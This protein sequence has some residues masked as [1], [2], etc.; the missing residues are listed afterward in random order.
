MGVVVRPPSPPKGGE[1]S[2]VTTTLEEQQT[3]LEHTD[4]HRAL[5]IPPVTPTPEKPRGRRQ[6]GKWVA[7]GASAGL[8]G[9]AI[10]YGVAAWNY[11]DEI[12]QLEN[13]AQV[14][15]QV[16]FG[17]FSGEY[18]AAREHLAQAQIADARLPTAFDNTY[19]A[20]REHLAQ[21]EIMAEQS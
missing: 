5:D 14:M 19:S 8:V 21:A 7:L 20:P 13:Q 9:L 15:T 11:T 4:I 18:G 1:V 10:G 2:Q 3:M 12:N 17:G 6:W 16:P